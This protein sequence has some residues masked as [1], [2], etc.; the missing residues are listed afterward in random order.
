MEEM[1]KLISMSSDNKRIAKNTFFLY[2]RM[3]VIMLVQ[4]YTSR[5]VLEVIGVDDYGVW[6]VVATLVVSISFITSSLASA[7]QRFLNIELGHDNEK[8]AHIVFN[9]SLVIYSLISLC[10]L[11]L[12]ECGGV[13]FINNKMSVP[14]GQLEV[15]NIVYQCVIISFLASLFRLPYDA[16]LIAYEHFN[17][18]AIFGIIEVFL[19][20]GIVFCLIWF[21]SFS[22][23]ILYGILTAAISIV[24]VIIIK[25]YCE[26]KFR[27]TRLKWVW[28]KQLVKQLLSFSGWSTFGA[29]A[30]MTANQGLGI[31]INI[32]FGVAVNAALGLANQVGNAVNQFVSNFQ[33]A[34]QPQITKRYAA[35][36]RESLITLMITSSKLSFFL[37]F[38]IGF[39]IIF[40]IDTLL[41]IWLTDVPEYTSDFCVYIILTALIEAVGAPLWMAIQAVGK[42]KKY[43]ISISIMLLMNVIL[44]YILFSCGASPE[45]ALEIKVAIITCCLGIKLAFSKKLLNFPIKRYFRSVIFASLSIGVFGWLIF[46]LE[47][48]ML[49][50]SALPFVIVSTSIF[51][52]C[53]I[54]LGWFIILSK[55]QRKIIISYFNKLL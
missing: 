2:I 20:L 40:N 52:I 14:E 10:L 50:L 33:T 7:T 38:L 24:L 48:K 26:H 22:H 23:L 17:F 3:G 6:S 21:S 32:F 36:E 34:F 41:N 49:H 13:W 19:K 9:E 27:I 46:A 39:P 15:T 51:L 42:I 53:S 18:Y 47:R 30:T 29:F 37:L 5:K 35:D 25:G 16:T 31:L 1:T 12:L 44:A 4:L 54:G 55:L 8:R 11:V 45:L 43:Q 28:D